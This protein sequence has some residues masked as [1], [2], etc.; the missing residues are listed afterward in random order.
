MF[1]KEFGPKDAPTVLFLHGAMVAGWM[2]DGQAEALMDYHVLVPDM[3]GFYRSHD[4]PWRSLR[5]TAVSLST[6]IADKAHGGKAHIVGLSLGGVMALHLAAT[7]PERVERLILSG[8]LTQ[9]VTGPMV[10]VQKLMLS[11]YHNSIGAKLVARMF[12]IPD[13]GMDDFMQTAK[14]TSKETNWRAISEIYEKP[15]PDGLTAVTRP[16]LVVSGA[17]DM[18]ITR[19]GVAFLVEKLPNAV[20]YLVPSVGHT[21]NAEDPILFNQMIQAWL[22]GAALPA[23]FQNVVDALFL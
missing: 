9:P 10:W 20:G 22:T 15:L 8:T 1:V 6:L 12:Q 17:K 19:N 11:I 2:W 7:A 21:W 14:L 13:D 18:A 4:D 23:S 16:T 5:E 3:P